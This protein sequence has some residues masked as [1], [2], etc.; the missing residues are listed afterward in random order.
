MQGRTR[1]ADAAA[2]TDHCWSGRT[3]P[4][5]RAVLGRR[6]Q[7]PAPVVSELQG[8]LTGH[9]PEPAEE[10]A[11]LAAL[12]AASRPPYRPPPRAATR[13]HDSS[14]LPVGP[15]PRHSLTSPEHL[16]L[17]T[18]APT[19]RRRF[20]ASEPRVRVDAGC[21]AEVRREQQ[22]HWPGPVAD[23]GRPTRRSP[24]VR[25]APVPQNDPLARSPPARVRAHQRPSRNTR[26]WKQFI[27]LQSPSSDARPPAANVLRY[28]TARRLSGARGACV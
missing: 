2:R 16:R 11:Q 25:P 22:R 12:T 28:S 8:R 13:T 26:S 9:L 27:R 19:G 15:T 24:P 14:T 20:P 7:H 21:L 10:T 6:R 23:G 1:S 5:G 17:E 4:A 18:T 3:V